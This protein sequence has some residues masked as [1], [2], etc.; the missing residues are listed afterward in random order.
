MLTGFV[1]RGTEFGRLESCLSLPRSVVLVEGEAGVGKS[2]LMQEFLAS[3]AVCT[4]SALV[5]LCPPFRRPFTLGPIVEG[6]RSWS[7]GVDDLRLDALAGALRPLFPEWAADLPPAPE[8]LQDSQAERSRLFAALAQLLDRL[9]VS[10]LVLEDVH[11][12][13]EATL[14]FLLQLTT[15]QPEGMGVL[16]TYRPT[17]VAPDSLLPR[18][19]SRVPPGSA[20][21]RLTLAPFDLA[22][23]TALVSSMLDGDPISD[24][25]ATYLYE[26]TEGLPLAVEESVRLLGDRSE[27]VRRKGAWLRRGDAD[28]E[29]APMVRDSVLQRVQPL[30]EHA[31]HILRAASVLAEPSDAA[32]LA[33]VSGL[34]AEQAHDGAVEAIGSGL[35]GEDTRGRVSF[36]H[37]LAAKAVYESITGPERRPLHLRAGHA[38]ADTSPQPLPRLVYHFR[39]AGDA[40]NWALYG[41]LAADVAI[42]AGDDST[43]VLLLNDLVSA[44]DLPV[45]TRSRLAKKLAGA[46]VFRRS[47]DSNL[48]RKVVTTLQGILGA[49]GLAAREQAEIRSPLGRLLMQLAEFE[50]GR[51]EL[52]RAIPDL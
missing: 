20:R 38:L 7:D 26:R 27:L 11:W 37:V 25:F 12:A 18:L 24:E 36:R 21:E 3:D 10:L 31:Q 41:E 22:Q 52:E 42:A 48:V 9:D 15:R 45:K 34:P 47:V 14:E 40:G 44:R 28:L 33:A 46:E 17:E 6:L 39:K 50:A 2:R 16:V 8:P 1:G 35:V 23:T 29:V 4:K 19:A 43:G 30:S 49:E 13:D 32:V 5:A 51:A